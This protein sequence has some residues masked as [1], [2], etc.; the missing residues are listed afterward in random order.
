[1]SGDIPRPLITYPG[2]STSERAKVLATARD[3]AGG[4]LFVVDN[5]PCHPENPRWPDQPADKCTVIVDDVG[6]P[7][8]CVEGYIADGHV[9][10]EAPTDSSETIRAVV[11]VAPSDL[12]TRVTTGDDVLLEVDKEYRARVALS[13]TR[14]HLAALALNATFASAWRKEAPV[15]D[16]LGNPDFD[17]LAI[18]SSVMDDTSSTDVYRIGKSL[19]KKGFTSEILEDLTPLSASLAATLD[20]WLAS[21]PVFTVESTKCPLDEQR[22][23]RC[24]LPTG[25]AAIPC[26][27][28]HVQHMTADDSFAVDLIWDGASLS[29]TMKTHDLSAA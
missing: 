23:W 5:T 10:V 28:T 4:L 20:E 15:R 26:G 8:Q 14:C 7:V 6:S 12:A 17:K 29:L 2:G 24:E 16:S 13:H 21:N 27:G 25:A 9:V 19:R 22:T 1:M 3:E 11:H 18:S